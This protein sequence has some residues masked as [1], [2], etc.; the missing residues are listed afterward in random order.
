MS[1]ATLAKLNGLDWIADHRISL[2]CLSDQAL[3]RFLQHHDVAQITFCLDNDNDAALQDGSPAPNWGQEA[4]FKYATKYADLGFATS[5]ETPNG[6]DVNED[7]CERRCKIEEE[8]KHGI[9]EEER[10]SIQEEYEL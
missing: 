4:A 2:G 8:R 5:I 1:H 6:K 7:L 9:R 3:A 10:L